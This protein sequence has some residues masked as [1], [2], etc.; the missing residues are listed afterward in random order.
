[1]LSFRFLL[2]RLHTDHVLGLALSCSMGRSE[3]VGLGFE[4][5]Q[6]YFRFGFGHCS[7]FVS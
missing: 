3:E 1:M 7:N 4:L 5:G 6:Y 2:S